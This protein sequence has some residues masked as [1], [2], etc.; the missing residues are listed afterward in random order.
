MWRCWG[1]VKG[2]AQVRFDR[3]LAETSTQNG[4]Y[5]GKAHLMRTDLVKKTT[6]LWLGNPGFPIEIVTRRVSAKRLIDPYNN[7]VFFIFPIVSTGYTLGIY[8]SYGFAGN[9]CANGKIDRVTVG[10]KG[11]SGV[12]A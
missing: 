2:A 8:K 1:G 10:S 6:Q 5:T 11:E 7:L 9:G 3:V 12:N 4:D